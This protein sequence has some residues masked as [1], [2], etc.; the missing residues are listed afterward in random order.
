MKRFPEIK[1]FEKKIRATKVYAD[2]VR[3]NKANFCLNCTGEE[4]LDCHHVISLYHMIN[5]WWTVYGN[6]KQVFIQI[7]SSHEKDEVDCITLCRNCHKVTHPG[8][9]AVVNLEPPLV[10]EWAVVPRGL[11]IGLSHMKMPVPNTLNLT[12]LQVMMG[13][14]W[15]IIGDKIKDRIIVFNRRRFADVIG[16]TPGTSFNNT[17]ELGLNQLELADVIIGYHIGGN[18]VETHMGASYLR[19]LQENPWFVP[20]KEVAAKRMCVLALRLFLSFQS[21]RLYKISLVKLIKNL[22]ITNKRQRQVLPMLRES[23]KS[24]G[25]ADFKHYKDEEPPFATQCEFKLSKRRATPIYSLR[26]ILNDVLER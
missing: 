12:G 9:R 17:L 26:E 20:L 4:D 19:R 25:W 2:W 3:R 6:E 15:Y 18:S 14:G 11:G 21:K 13:L 1:A 22:G 24:I 8:R 5:S 10:E 23:C 7:I 16:K